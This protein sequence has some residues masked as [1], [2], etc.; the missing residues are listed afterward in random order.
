MTPLQG[1]PT[2]FPYQDL[3]LV[4]VLLFSVYP[5]T[6]IYA[7]DNNEPVIKEWV[8]GNDENTT[9]RFFYYSIERGWLRD[10]IEGSISHFDLINKANGRV[11]YFL[12]EV[13][14]ENS[15]CFQVFLSSIPDNY[16]PKKTFLFDSDDGVDT[17]LIFDYFR[18]NELATVIPIEVKKVSQDEK[19]ETIYIRL[20]EGKGIGKGS[21]RTAVYASTLSKFDNLYKAIALDYSIG[22]DRPNIELA[23]KINQKYEILTETEIFGQSIRASFGFMIRPFSNYLEKF[24]ANTPATDIV[25]KVTTLINRTKKS[26]ELED[27]CN[28]HSRFTINSYENFLAEVYKQEL[29]LELSYFNPINKDEKSA[30]LNYLN[31]NL[32]IEGIRS[33][34]FKNSVEEKLKGKFRAIDCKT[35]HFL[36]IST[37]ENEYRGSFDE[38]RKEASPDFNFR[39]IYDVIMQRATEKKPGQKDK[40]KY[41]MISCI[42]DSNKKMN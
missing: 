37:D 42:E 25:T 1:I 5:S 12:D 15:D 31:A 14:G 36:F 6:I 4:G 2:E 7:D 28:S 29:H 30:T 18:L 11:V 26:N 27:E 19:S 16:F 22:I 3:K 32:I 10:F 34:S 9:D 21:I 13:K 17:D 39:S 24:N 8:D 23:A 35:G 41:T 20:K 33:L 38:L 40:I